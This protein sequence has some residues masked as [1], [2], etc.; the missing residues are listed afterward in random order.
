MVLVGVVV[1]VMAMM[2][3]ATMVAFGFALVEESPAK[4]GGLYA[5]LGNPRSSPQYTLTTPTREPIT[6]VFSLIIP[7][8][9][10]PLILH[11]YQLVNSLCISF[12]VRPVRAPVAPEKP[13]AQQGETA[14]EAHREGQQGGQSGPV[15]PTHQRPLVPISCELHIGRVPADPASFYTT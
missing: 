1:V 9:A 8:I 15:R 12:R 11:F 7:G 4:S 2:V 5:G 6:G 3:V 13:R 10:L 14:S